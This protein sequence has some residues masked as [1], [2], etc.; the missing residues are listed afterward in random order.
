VQGSKD[1]WYESGSQAIA[2]NEWTGTITYNGAKVSP[3]VLMSNGAN[4][5]QFTLNVTPRASLKGPLS[6]MRPF[7]FSLGFIW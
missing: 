3:K 1:P 4:Q 5:V 2:V 7:P 6:E